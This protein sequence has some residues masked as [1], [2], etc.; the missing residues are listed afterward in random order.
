M[1]VTNNDS[2]LSKGT[3]FVTSTLGNTVGGV[4]KTIGGVVG[5]GGRGVGETITNVTGK[6]GAPVGDGIASLATGIENGTR[7]VAEGVE[8]AGRGR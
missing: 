2:G 3:I 1:P 6:T 8:D 4:A 5:A 7:K